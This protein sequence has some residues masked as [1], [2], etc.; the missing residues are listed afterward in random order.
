MC[1]HCIIHHDWNKLHLHLL[2]LCRQVIVDLGHVT[3]GD[4]SDWSKDDES[5]FEIGVEED[6]EEDD[7]GT[8]M[9]AYQYAHLVDGLN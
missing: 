8:R 4:V 9:S 3:F 7:D 1:N 5:S 6:W 2:V